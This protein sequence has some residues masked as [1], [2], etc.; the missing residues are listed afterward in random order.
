L[1]LG[2]RVALATLGLVLFAVWG[3]TYRFADHLSNDM[4]A[5]LFAQQA[6]RVEFIANSLDQA[7]KIRL[8][9]LSSVASTVKLPLLR[10]PKAVQDELARHALLGGLFDLGLFVVGAD[11]AGIADF[12]VMKGRATADYTGREYFRKV[13]ETGRPAIGKPVM[14]RF[15]NTPVLLMAVPITDREGKVAAVLVGA[16]RIHGSDLFN[17]IQTRQGPEQG[18]IHVVS[19]VDR[20]FVASTEKGR[21]MTPIAARG[22]N[23]L[24]D[25]YL[26]GYNGSG[27]MVNSKGMEGL[28]SGKHIPTT[29]WIVTAFLP[30]S[31]AL[32]PARE[33]QSAAYREAALISLFAAIAIG[34]YIRRNLS[35]LSEAAR[36]LDEMAGREEEIQRLPV[37]GAPE[38]RVLFENFNRLHTRLSAKD[39]DLKEA[40]DD[41]REKQELLIADIARREAAER[42]LEDS[43]DRFRNYVRNAPYGVFVAD[44]NGRYVDVNPAAARITGY[45]EAELL[46]MA[47]PDLLPPESLEWGAESFRIVKETGQMT[48]ETAFRRKGGEIGYWHLNGVRLSEDRYLGFVADITERRRAWDERLRLEAQIQ[49]AQKLESLGVLAGG[50]AHDFNNILMT[51]LG[52]AN[53]AASSLGP[54]SPAAGHLKLIEQAA[55]RAAELSRQMLAYSGKGRFVIERLDLSRLV[56]EMVQM[57]EVSISKNAATR[58]ELATSLPA[59]AADATQLRQVIMNLVLNA[60]EAIGEGSGLITLG[61]GTLICGR[62]YLKEFWLDELLEE[63]LYVYLDVSDTGCGMDPDTVSRIFDPFFTTKFTGRGLGMAAVLGIVRGHGGAIRVSSKPGVGTTFRILLPALTHPPERPDPVAKPGEWR[64]DGTVLLVDDEESVR[65]TGREM[66]RSLGYEVVTASDGMEAIGIVA[67]RD[68][69]TLVILDL[70]MPNMDGE[71]CFREMRRRGTNV[72]VIMTSGYNQ[73]EVTR[74]FVGQGLA[75]FLQKPYSLSALREAIRAA[76]EGGRATPD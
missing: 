59:V 76:V 31:V 54:D 36:R 65:E 72:R 67:S 4:R 40:L 19:P 48:G 74:K 44:A 38:L 9:S 1:P 35:P 49:Q 21:V 34:I 14:G 7:F 11:G 13:M 15:A 23:R 71:H 33:R 50:I 68:D 6:A 55:N 63:G 25:R 18:E 28:S 2:V 26:A 10:N 61:T 57:L 39:A 46:R 42:D 37:E 75:G 30:T 12:P 45:S 73:Q 5:L 47:I 3:V 17:E 62:E 27:V 20:I 16:N 22:V 66:L 69:I 60:S 51:V 53:L 56:E 43:E 64:G 70:T 58:F 52:N 32:A 8:D 29:G 41:L 24:L